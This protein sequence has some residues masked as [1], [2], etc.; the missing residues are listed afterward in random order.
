MRLPRVSTTIRLIVLI[1]ETVV[2]AKE[3]IAMFRTIA[4][5]VREDR[6]AANEAKSAP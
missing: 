1:G 4:R 3:W 2:V 6:E 5:L